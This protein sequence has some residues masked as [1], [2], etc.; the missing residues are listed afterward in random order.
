MIRNSWQKQKMDDR[1][2]SDSNVKVAVRVRPMN[3]RGES[4]QTWDDHIL[5]VCVFIIYEP[6]LDL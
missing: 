1:T 2:Q 5:C 3:R 6:N 4:L